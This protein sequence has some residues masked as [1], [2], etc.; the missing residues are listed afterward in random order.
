MGSQVTGGLEIPFPKP[1]KNRVIHPSK[2][3]HLHWFFGSTSKYIDRKKC[4]NIQGD[5]HL[6]RR[7][8]QKEINVAMTLFFKSWPLLD[9]F[10]GDLW[11]E[12]VTSIL[13]N[14]RSLWRSL[15]TSGI[16]F[17]YIYINIKY[18]SI[19]IYVYVNTK[20]RVYI[21]VYIYALLSQLRFMPTSSS[22]IVQ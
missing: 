2:G 18:N 16:S 11:A 19:I 6:T 10:F 13:G 4:V 1:A 7:M 8:E 22:Y 17:I 12:N 15:D 14:Q 3:G 9:P 21:Y 20:V 5:L